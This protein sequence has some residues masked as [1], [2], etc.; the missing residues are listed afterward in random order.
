MSANTAQEAPP[1]PAPEP[2]CGQAGD[3]FR[4]LCDLGFADALDALHAGRRPAPPPSGRPSSL[5]EAAGAEAPAEATTGA[6]PELSLALGDVFREIGYRGA[7]ARLAAIMYDVS[8]E[9]GAEV[10]IARLRDDFFPFAL[11][12]SAPWRELLEFVLDWA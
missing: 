12:S 3:F 10:P 6:E 1:R 9:A 11:A 7:Y 2:T 4:L 8:E 5:A